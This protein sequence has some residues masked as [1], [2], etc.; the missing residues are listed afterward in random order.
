M[1]LEIYEEA[2]SLMD[3]ITLSQ[4]ILDVLTAEETL[5]RYSIGYRFTEFAEQFKEEFTEFVSSLLEENKKKFDELNCGCED[6]GN[7]DG[8][9]DSDGTKN[10]DE[11]IDWDD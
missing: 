5:R 7:P 3:K 2:K 9:G 4:E 8:D 10:P 11:D 6:C 1:K